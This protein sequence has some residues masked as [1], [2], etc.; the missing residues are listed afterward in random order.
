MLPNVTCTK[1]LEAAQKVNCC[2]G[3]GPKQVAIPRSD[4]TSCVDLCV[5]LVVS[6]SR[7]HNDAQHAIDQVRSQSITEKVWDHAA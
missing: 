2:R 4:I 6:A 7:R 5:A 1:D 3:Q